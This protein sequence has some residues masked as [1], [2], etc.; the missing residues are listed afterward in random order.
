MVHSQHVS[1]AFSGNWFTG[2]L[3]GD[4]FLVHSVGNVV[5]PT[6]ELL[7]QSSVS[8]VGGDWNMAGL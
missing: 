7:D 3:Q 8:M 1:T 2:D 5:T 4:V 6:D